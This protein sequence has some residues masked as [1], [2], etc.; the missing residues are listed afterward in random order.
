[1]QIDEL[2]REVESLSVSYAERNG[3]DRTDEWLLL[4]LNEEVGELTQAFL[5][6]SGQARDK[7]RDDHELRAD[8]RAELADVLAHV[9]L[10]AERFDIDVSAE[11][12]R[13]WLSRRPVE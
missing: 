2:R 8:L 13:T 3:I 7:G 1:M 4:K 6:R 5:A 10:I 12:R 11:I 9:L